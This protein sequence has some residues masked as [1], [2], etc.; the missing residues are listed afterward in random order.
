MN[1]RSAAFLCRFLFF[2][3]T[4][5]MV[6]CNVGPEFRRPETPVHPTWKQGSPEQYDALGLSSLN[7]QMNQH[8][9]HD[10]DD[11]VLAGL[12]EQATS[13]NPDLQE[14]AFRVIESRAR[15]G[16]ARTQGLPDLSANGEYN[17][18]KVSGNSSPFALRSQD[19]FP[20]YSLG[21]GTAWQL[22]FWGRFRRLTEAA[23]AEIGV[24]A[25]ERDAIRLT[26][27]SDVASA[28]IT[29]RSSEARIA[30]ARANLD[31]Q[32]QILELVE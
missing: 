13:C 22:D 24:A 6:G 17:F 3:A 8:W 5:A 9:W 7:V 4:Y 32:R 16:D 30:V 18:R 28:Y 14:A 2:V 10:F 11:P 29:I 25:H 15:F 23:Q 12:V 27:Q 21:F 1:F 31:L 26:I 20:L 19:S